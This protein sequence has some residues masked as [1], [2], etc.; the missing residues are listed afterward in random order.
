[1]T[2]AEKEFVKNMAESERSVL[3]EFI[4]TVQEIALLEELKNTS[5]TQTA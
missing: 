1:M 3:S 5:E 4:E 2:N